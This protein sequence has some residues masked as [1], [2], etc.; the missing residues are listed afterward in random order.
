MLI[1]PQEFFVRIVVII[2]VI[3]ARSFMVSIHV[4][5]VPTIIIFIIFIIFIF[6]RIPM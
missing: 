4:N 1:T 3:F 2:A 5:P 6:Q